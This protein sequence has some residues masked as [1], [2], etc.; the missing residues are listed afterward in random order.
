M[1]KVMFGFSYE[2]SKRLSR[3]KVSNDNV[4]VTRMSFIIYQGCFRKS[5]E[6]GLDLYG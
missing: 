2:K 1:K 6:C 3:R 4:K 5:Y